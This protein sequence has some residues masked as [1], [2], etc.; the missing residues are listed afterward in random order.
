MKKWLITLIGLLITAN[1][2]AL[3]VVEGS[4]DYQV[5]DVSLRDLNRITCSGGKLSKI[6]YSKEKG[7][8]IQQV[9]SDFYVKVIPVEETDPFGRKKIVYKAKPTE[10]YAYCSGKVFSL[11]LN[12]KDIPAETVVL[13]I[14][15]TNRKEAESFEKANPYEETLL[16]LIKYAYKENIPPGYTA[17]EV[18][19]IVRDYQNLE[20]ALKRVYTGDSFK[21]YEYI[22][23]A[24]LPVSLTE[25]QFL[26]LVSNPQAISIV[27][28]SL[29]KG[30]V[31]RLLIVARNQNE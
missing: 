23:T 13:K 31:T 6:I 1:S 8:M 28:P 19:R 7:I 30:E 26:K 25:A 11:I 14:R 5:V 10:V 15:K 2:Y 18:N 29:S 21:V 24:K 20:V 16:K 9:G 17:R 4:S 12:P 27:K 22:L 3:Q